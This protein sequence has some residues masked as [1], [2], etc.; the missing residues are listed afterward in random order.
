MSRIKNR[1]QHRSHGTLIRSKRNQLVSVFYAQ[2]DTSEWRQ[3]R[4]RTVSLAKAEEMEKA[5]E[6]ERVVRQYEG[7]PQCVGFRAKSPLRASQTSPCTLT[8]ATTIAVGKRALGQRLS[9]GETA[10]VAKFIAWP[11]IGDTKAPA[12]R[13]R[14]TESE[15]LQAESLLGMHGEEAR[16]NTERTLGVMN[17]PRMAATA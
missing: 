8:M 12:V 17:V 7:K 2:Q 3:W 11:L 4:Y 16:R 14:I 1:T 6:V 13:P 9:R 10:H 5:G 15:R